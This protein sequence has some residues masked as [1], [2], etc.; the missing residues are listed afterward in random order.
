MQDA[1]LRAL[2][3]SGGSMR[4]VDI[5]SE[6]ARGGNAGV[7]RAVLQELVDAALVDGPTPT[8]LD[9]RLTAEG[10]RFIGKP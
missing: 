1:I 10:W 8:R 9:Y 4:V 3:R 5:L 7:I 2:A 6:I